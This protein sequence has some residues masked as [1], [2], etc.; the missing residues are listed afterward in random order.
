MNAKVYVICQSWLLK[1]EADNT[2]SGFDHSSY[3]AKTETNNWFIIYYLFR[4]LHSC[5]L[6]ILPNNG[7]SFC[8]LQKSSFLWNAK[9]KP[10]CFCSWC[11]IVLMHD[12]MAHNNFLDVS[13]YTRWR[14]RKTKHYIEELTHCRFILPDCSTSCPCR[15]TTRHLLPPCS[16]SGKQKRSTRV[17]LV[18]YISSFNK[19]F[20]RK[21]FH[22]EKKFENLK[23]KIS[24]NIKNTLSDIRVACS[25]SLPTR[26]SRNAK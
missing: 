9:E 10:F 12:V 26:V 15:V 20:C 8:H 2:N 14:G 18:F 1:A 24:R 4:H 3:H 5:A 19:M 25:R 11:H 6:K 23:F 22:F 16:V 7:E 17:L 13:Y 21:L